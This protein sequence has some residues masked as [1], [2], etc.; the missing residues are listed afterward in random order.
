M[1]VYTSVSRAELEAFLLRYSQG[2]LVDYQGISAGIENTN[3]FV[4]TSGGR[5]VLT[6]FE[7]LAAEQLGYYLQ[8][9]AYLNEHGVACAH[10]VAGN[11]NQ[12]VHHLN[13][14]PATLMQRLHGE[15]VLHATATQCQALGKLLARMHIAGDGFDLQQENPRG[16]QWLQATG[17][18]LLPLLDES[19]AQ[20]VRQ[21]LHYLASHYNRDLPRG[22]IHADLFRDNVLFTGNEVSGVVDFYNACDDALLYDLAITVN[23]W[24]VDNE[25]SLDINRAGALCHAYQSLR[26]ITDSERRAWPVLL[27]RAAL[28]FWLSRLWDSC[29]PK[30]GELTFLKPPDE[31]KHILLGHRGAPQLAET[32]WHSRL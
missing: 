14:K 10:P 9:M 1:S 20:L 6:L 18:Q 31:F 25:G 27:R 13:G 30:P 29:H 28:R 7:V 15:S 22:A 26:P 23:D 17:E 16:V 8:L 32:V 12:Y 19:D 4:T 24:C 2:E 3:Y 21:E 11:N 5:Y